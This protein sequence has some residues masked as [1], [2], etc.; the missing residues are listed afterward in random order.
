MQFPLLSTTINTSSMRT[1]HI[2]T[3]WSN[4]ICYVSLDANVY[5]EIRS[6]GGIHLEEVVTGC[7]EWTSLTGVA[8]GE[9]WDQRYC[10]H[11]ISAD[12]YMV[13]V[14][15]GGVLSQYLLINGVIKISSIPID[16]HT[17]YYGGVIN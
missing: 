13:N 4:G 3:S 5:T 16:L 10:Y 11:V 12:R 15:A 14:Y 6:I 7:Y 17:S 9:E 8:I 2:N 1:H